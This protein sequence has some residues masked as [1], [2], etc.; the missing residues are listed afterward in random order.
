MVSSGIIFQILFISQTFIGFMGNS[1]LF[2]SCTY[3]FLI[4]SHKKPVDVILAHLTLANAVTLVLRGFPNIMSSFGIKHGI[5]DMGCK[6]VLYIQRVTRSI[7]LNATSLQSMFQAVTIT[8]SNYKWAWLKNKVS[9]YILPSLLFFWIINMIIYFDIIVRVVATINSSDIR[10]GYY[11]PYCKTI[12]FEFYQAVS[13]L[14]VVLIQDLL[15]LSLMTFN[16]VYMVN[17]LYRHHRTVQHVRSSSQSSQRF[18]EERA[19]R[20]ILILVSCF[21]FFYLINSFLTIYLTFA[22]E[23]NWDLDKFS[24]FISSCYPTICPFLLIKNKNIISRL[25]SMRIRIR[26]LSFKRT[27]NKLPNKDFVES[28]KEGSSLSQIQNQSQSKGKEGSVRNHPQLQITE[29]PYIT[30]LLEA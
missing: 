11:T 8:P 14:S 16:S 20:T 5:D 30:Q 2:I 24:D 28:K 18:P 29:E 9:V 22:S 23:K 4:H 21:V 7:S 1:L 12:A 15:F 27:L 3:T 17:I 19:T 10:R 13:F 6:T 25:S 26:I